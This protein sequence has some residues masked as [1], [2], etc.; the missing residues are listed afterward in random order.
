L[1]TANPLVSVVIPNYNYGH[2]LAQAIESVLDQSYKNIQLVI[3]DNESTDNSIEVAMRYS[4]DSTLIQKRHGGVSSARNLGF[5]QTMGEYICFLD[6]DDTWLPGKLAR[7]VQALA[8]SSAGVVYSGVN[9]CDED[10]KR[11]AVLQPKYRGK[12]SENYFKYPTS[13]IILLGCSNAMIRR[14]IA[15][16]VGDFNIALHHSADWDYFRRVCDLTDV[17]Y[18][19]DLHVNYRRHQRSMSSGSLLEINRDNEL[20]I[21]EFLRDIRIPMAPKYTTMEQ[22]GLWMRF[23]FLATKSLLR[24]GFISDAIKRFGRILLF[25]SV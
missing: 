3:V 9:L 16:A 23:Q 22:F 7:Q 17:E 15:A 12:C 2:F 14:E 19:S 18:L 4:A 11:Y 21:L 25:G 20:A 13:A 5:A 10:M 8:S 6:S 24:A 1:P